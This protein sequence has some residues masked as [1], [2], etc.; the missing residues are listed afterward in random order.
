LKNKF[1][2]GELFS[3]YYLIIK[4]IDILFISR[5]FEKNLLTIIYCN[6]TSKSILSFLKISKNINEDFDVLN[7]ARIHKIMK[8]D[9]VR[10]FPIKT[11]LSLKF[12]IHF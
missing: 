8:T 11:F 6:R 7:E 9:V 12:Q 1:I 3:L 10:H 2:F 4:Y 5:H